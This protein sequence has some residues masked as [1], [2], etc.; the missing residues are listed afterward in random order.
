MTNGVSF[1]ER[2]ALIRRYV[3]ALHGF[4][5]TSL[6]GVSLRER[7]RVNDIDFWAASPMRESS[8]WHSP[9]FACLDRLRLSH[10]DRL[11]GAR[12]CRRRVRPRMRAMLHFALSLISSLANRAGRLEGQIL[13]VAYMPESSSTVSD[14]EVLRRYFG[15]LP[16]H[17]ESIG[18][19]PAVLF[20]PTNSPIARM[21]QG[22][23]RTYS[24]MK[25]TLST[26][27][28]TSSISPRSVIR[29][30]RSWV[31]LQRQVPSQRQ[32]SAVL[33]ATGDIAQMYP[34]WQDEF[35][36]SM[37]GRSAARTALL[38][39][40]FLSALKGSR[41]IKLVVYPF[42]GQGWEACL[43]STARQCGIPTIA[44]LHTIMKPWDVRAHTCLREA[45]PHRLALHGVH[46]QQELGRIETSYVTVE[47]LRYAYL[48]ERREK[49][50][51][52]KRS[53]LLVVLGSDCENSFQ[54]FAE[55]I[56]EIAARALPWTIVVKAHPQCTQI[57]DMSRQ[58][59]LATGSLSE[60]LRN[61][62]AVFLCGT[63]APLDS[64]LFGLPTAALLE[65]AGYSMN[66]L[67][68]NDAYFVGNSIADVVRWL[69]SAMQREFPQPDATPFF[70]L[71]EGFDKWTDAIRSVIR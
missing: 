48:R 44:Y 17:L 39:E 59:R 11:E 25:R 69:D 61:C 58:V 26:A 53:E 10:P 3:D 32:I 6:R 13:F 28:I 27:V 54:Q 62:R 68:P 7:L 38:Y 71:S 21:T 5:K 14:V 20:L 24:T 40:G 41:G 50:D 55:L 45:P 51:D 65:E 18:L 23:R 67:Q 8:P 4:G 36:E 70:D 35:A 2:M 56:T 16:E 15:G 66:P 34:L 57:P 63:A 43:E 42:E 1:D 12:S 64:Y 31:R 52:S 30:L 22:E 29:A 33:P 49:R 19:R 9:L 46:D 47:A 37:C 60:A